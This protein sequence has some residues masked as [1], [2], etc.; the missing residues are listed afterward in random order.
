M[1]TQVLR[2]DTSLFGDQGASSQLSDTLIEHLQA[3]HGEL[4]VTRRNLAVDSLPY[5]GMEVITALA[6]D[7]VALSGAQRALVAL[8]DQL[9]EEVQNADILV[10]AAP[11]YNFTVPSTLKTWMDYVAR[12]G[13]TFKYTETGVVGLLGAKKVYVVASRGGIHRDAPS[14]A[15]VPLLR[16]YFA[17]LGTDIDVIYAEGLNMGDEPRARGFAAARERIKVLAA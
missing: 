17:L 15:V 2:L 6:T 14:D 3:S 13:V 10:V 9:I 7:P 16:N 5:F 12:A 8:A 1:T 11:M 4:S